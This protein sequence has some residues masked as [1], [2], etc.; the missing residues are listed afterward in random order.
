MVTWLWELKAP[1][2]HFLEYRGGDTEVIGRNLTFKRLPRQAGDGAEIYK[3]ETDISPLE[4]S[5]SHGTGG[6]CEG[7]QTSRGKEWGGVSL[8][9]S[10]SWLYHI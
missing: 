6:H 4:V 7:R 10:S 5:N 3:R 2:K 9:G 8:E 1:H